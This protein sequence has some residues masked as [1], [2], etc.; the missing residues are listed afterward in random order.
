MTENK[1]NRLDGYIICGKHWFENVD[2]GF[3]VINKDGSSNLFDLT[4]YTLDHIEKLAVEMELDSWES[5]G[6]ILYVRNG[7]VDTIYSPVELNR[8]YKLG[9]I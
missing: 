8:K 9:K 6:R 1:I 5:F 4:N 7:I 2:V 3:K